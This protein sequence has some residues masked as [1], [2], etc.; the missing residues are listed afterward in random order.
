[1][2][3]NEIVETDYSKVNVDKIVIEIEVDYIVVYQKSQ[4]DDEVDI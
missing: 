2:A 1:M 3:I 4:V